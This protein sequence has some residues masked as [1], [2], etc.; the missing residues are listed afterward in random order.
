MTK[1]TNVK[2]SDD[3]KKLYGKE[4]VEK[5]SKIQSSFRIERFLKYVELNKNDRVVDFACGNGMLMQHIALRVSSYVGV[6]FSEEFIK[7]AIE[8]KG[9]LKIK[10]ASFACSNINEFCENNIQSFDC[11][12]ALDFFEHIYDE[13]LLEILTSINKSLKTGGRLYIH[14]PNSLFFIEKMKEHSFILNQFPEHIAV[15]SPEEIVKLLEEA[16][17][18]SKKVLLLPHYNMLKY[19]HFI[20]YFPFFGK[21]FKARIFIEAVK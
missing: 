8:K 17:F 15:R 19:V 3:L 10:N 13:E 20:S 21:Y 12:F 5:F 18:S 7:E 1:D 6:D 2:S 14:T 16:G 4:Y 9:F 11:A